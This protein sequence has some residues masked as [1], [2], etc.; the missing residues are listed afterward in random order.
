VLGRWALVIVDAISVAA[1]GDVPEKGAIL[2]KD[3]LTTAST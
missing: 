3:G 2:L 1:S